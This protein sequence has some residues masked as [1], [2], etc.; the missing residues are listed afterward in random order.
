MSSYPPAAEAVAF[1]AQVLLVED[2][3]SVRQFIARSLEKRGYLVSQA[4]TAEEALE[5]LLRSRYLETGPVDIIVSDV[6]LPAGSGV[7]LVR[8][9]RATPHFQRVPVVLISGALAHPSELGVEV[10]A[11]TDFL[12]KPFASEALVERLSSLLARARRGSAEA[13]P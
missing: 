1:R 6:G 2:D 5:T 3:V 9:A 11:I 8:E 10:D 7:D 4:G 12:N 13:E